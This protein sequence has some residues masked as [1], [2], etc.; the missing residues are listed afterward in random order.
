MENTVTTLNVASKSYKKEVFYITLN[1]DINVIEFEFKNSDLL[2]LLKEHVSQARLNKD[3]KTY[4]APITNLNVERVEDF[5]KGC[6]ATLG[7]IRQIFD[8]DFRVL[9]TTAVVDTPK[10][11][12]K[13]AVSGEISEIKPSIKDRADYR[14]IKEGQVMDKNSKAGDDAKDIFT[15]GII[16]IQDQ[17]NTYKEIKELAVYKM[18]KE[19]L[20]Y[21]INNNLVYYY[22]E[23][24]KCFE[25]NGIN[26]SIEPEIT[27]VM[28]NNGFENYTKDS[29]IA[30]IVNSIENYLKA[31]KRMDDLRIK[32]F[33]VNSNIG[34]LSMVL[35][36]KESG[37]MGFRVVDA[38][39]ENKAILNM[40]V[41]INTSNIKNEAGEIWN[42][43][44]DLRDNKFYYDFTV[45]KTQDIH[46]LYLD[47]LF[48]SKNFYRVAQMYIGNILTGRKV[49]KI[50]QLLGE[51]GD[52]KSE[53]IEALKEMYGVH[54]TQDFKLNKKKD[55][56]E[57]FS[58]QCLLNNQILAYVTEVN[59]D[60]FD[61]IMFKNLSG[62]THVSIPVKGSYPR[63]IDTTTIQF[64]MALNYTNIFRIPDI[65]PSMIRRI[66]CIKTVKQTG[67]KILNLMK[68]MINGLY[69]P[70]LKKTFKP[71]RLEFF[72]WMLEGAIMAYESNAF[73]EDNMA[74]EVYGQ[75]VFDFNQEM[76]NRMAGTSQFLEDEEFE[77]LRDGSLTKKTH[78][79]EY[80]LE[81]CEENKIPLKERIGTTKLI[82]SIITEARNKYGYNLDE[83]MRCKLPNG[84]LV[85]GLPIKFKHDKNAKANIF[86]TIS[87]KAVAR[88]KV[89]DE[90]EVEAKEKEV[91]EVEKKENEK[92]EKEFTKQEEVKK[93]NVKQEDISDF[94]TDFA[95]DLKEK[96]IEE[97]KEDYKREMYKKFDSR[98]IELNE[99]IKN[100]KDV[101]EANKLITER[102]SLVA[103]K[104][105]AKI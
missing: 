7:D 14:D 41:E 6:Y 52:G 22:N 31:E 10:F 1:K 24:T 17:K 84:K 85:D 4:Q 28:L 82:T 58:Y 26:D 33:N 37:K 61:D 77:F 89:L 2:K 75:D 56:G 12:F 95:E 63:T 65:D 86:M 18:V 25:S 71:Q 70:E 49:S 97:I 34:T 23:D 101:K 51:G 43:L 78:I 42:G 64:I 104:N 38:C 99:L 19:N 47:K 32:Y 68:K 48:A 9:K 93:E 46:T 44:D 102:N 76:V 55:G 60:T 8:F 91:K 79:M 30:S 54:K 83:R 74:A 94:G 103:F 88:S 62:D 98:I 59:K 73:V 40:V 29:D 87:M 69:S 13:E 92:Y 96:I 80:Y 20:A 35:T 67:T 105:M 57:N 45:D 53:F 5:I 27:S 81:Y 100:E 21:N 66:C 50:A 39:R 11:S 72:H 36:Q 90:K 16:R 15:N 3:T